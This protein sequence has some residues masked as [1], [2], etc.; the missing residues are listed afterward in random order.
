MKK[1]LI[2]ILL[3]FYSAAF[4]NDEPKF[5]E[6][7]NLLS[8]KKQLATASQLIRTIESDFTQTKVL[9]VL[10]EKIITRGRFY[11]KA[12]NCVRWEYVHP[13]RY[14]IIINDRK[15]TIQNENRVSNYG[16]QSNT[17][18]HE[19]NDLIMACLQGKIS[20]NSN[21]QLQLFEN[22][23]MYL[24]KLSPVTP[25]LKRFLYRIDIYFN[26]RDNSVAKL[27]MLEIGGDYTKIDFHNK[28]FNHEINDSVFVV[29]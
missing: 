4:A 21:F 18:M 27:Y 29:D 17:I 3:L 20:D 1:L 22:A 8:I 11:F 24:A 9:S 25:K 13:F 14:L 16:V 10:S 19:V 6:V 2:Y 7:Q 28:K 5:V 23:Q 15:I 12:D 26:K